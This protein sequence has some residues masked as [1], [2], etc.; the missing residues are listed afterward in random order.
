V[1]RGTRGATPRGVRRSI[2]SEK[3]GEKLAAAAVAS[4]ELAARER[5]SDNRDDGAALQP[6]ARGA[7]GRRGAPV[8]SRIAKLV[9]RLCP[10]GKALLDCA[11]RLGCRNFSS[12]S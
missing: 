2:S 7:S 9:A 5:E 8:E 3:E 6:G 4:G 10:V 12:V 1:A 11:L